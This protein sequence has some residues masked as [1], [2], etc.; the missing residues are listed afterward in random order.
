MT[1][2]QFGSIRKLRS[3]RWQAR[4]GSETGQML[5]APHTFKT[6]ADASAWLSAVETDLRRGTFIDPRA[7]QETLRS[8]T[9]RWMVSR[10][11]LRPKTVGLYGMLIDRCVLPS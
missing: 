1:R 7:G 11:D 2:R 6:K 5:V 8:Y 4:Y 10:P 3:G 9:E